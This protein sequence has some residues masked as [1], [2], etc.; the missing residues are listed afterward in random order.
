MSSILESLVAACTRLT[1]INDSQLYM[2]SVSPCFYTHYSD[3]NF[4]FES[5]SC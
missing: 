4:L 1:S 3:K 5:V 2:A